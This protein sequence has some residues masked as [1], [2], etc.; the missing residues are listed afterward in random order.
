MS[1]STLKLFLAFSIIILISQIEQIL[2]KEEKIK[3]KEN[4]VNEILKKKSKNPKVTNKSESSN[5]FIG[6]K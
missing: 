6:K 3:F 4:F 2:S 1:K 5:L